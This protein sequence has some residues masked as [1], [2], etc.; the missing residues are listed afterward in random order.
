MGHFF[1]ISCKITYKQVGDVHVFLHFYDRT[2]NR[3][4][5]CD[6][7]GL[8]MRPEDTSLKQRNGILNLRKKYYVQNIKQICFSKN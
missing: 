5:S 1:K 7:I 3:Q 8:L 2:E 6:V 4:L